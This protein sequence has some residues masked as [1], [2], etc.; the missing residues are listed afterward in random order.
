MGDNNLYH[1]AQ[2][3]QRY[4]GNS[5]ENTKHLK[6]LNFDLHNPNNIKYVEFHDLRLKKHVLNDL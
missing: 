2:I 6:L 4:L 1:W 3:N 5:L